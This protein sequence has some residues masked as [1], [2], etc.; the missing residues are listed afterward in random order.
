MKP[1]K[2]HAHRKTDLYPDDKSDKATSDETAILEKLKLQNAAL[3]KI[4]TAVY[5]DNGTS[6]DESEN[7]NM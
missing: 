3:E 5:A 6:N 2:M 7:M 4:K 1:K